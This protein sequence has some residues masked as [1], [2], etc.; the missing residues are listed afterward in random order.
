MCQDLVCLDL[1]CQE[2]LGDRL[3]RWPIRLATRDRLQVFAPDD[4][5]SVRPAGRGHG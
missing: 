2:E 3:A 1:V 5:V 4:L